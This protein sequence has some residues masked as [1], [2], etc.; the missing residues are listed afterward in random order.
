MSDSKL[1]S[2]DYS[3][4]R[5]FNYQCSA[6]STSFENWMCFRPDLV[7]LELRR[8][9]QYFPQFNTVRYWLSWDAFI[10]NPRRFTA[11]F[12]TALQ[13]ADSLGLLA[14]PI[15]LNRWHCVHQDNGGVYLENIIPGLGWSFDPL[16]YR[17]Y[18][19]VI[20]GEHRNDRRI[21]AWDLCNEPF[22]YNKPLKDLGEIPALEFNWLKGMY[23]YVK[24]MPVSQAVSFGAHGM[25]ELLPIQE[26][27]ER[28]HEQYAALMDIIMIHPYYIGEQNDLPKKAVYEQ[29][30]DFFTALARKQNKGIIATETCWGSLDDEWRIENLRY[31]MG[32][33]KKRNIGMVPHAL[34]HSL[35]PDLHLPEYGPVGLPGDLRFINADGSLRKGHEAYNEY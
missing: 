4:V 27:W 8:G 26:E 1:K 32:E 24:A 3:W 14:M 10:R 21:L 5:G 33:L 25:R 35:A 9:K 34:H 6:G 23:D 16:F 29:T 30:L 15:L 20:I 22:T 11:D 31:S 12:E 2:N 17:Q 13:I 19:D 7:E 18:F 28:W